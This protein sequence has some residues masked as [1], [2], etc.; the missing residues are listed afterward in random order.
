MFASMR[1]RWRRDLLVA[2]L[3]SVVTSAVLLPVGWTALQQQRERTEDACQLALQAARLAQQ[4]AAQARDQAQRAMVDQASDLAGSFGGPRK[5]DA[6]AMQVTTA[7]VA[8]EVP[9]GAYLL[10]DKKAFSFAIGDIVVFRVGEKNY[11]GRV[12]AVHRE[13]GQ[14]TIGRNKEADRQVPLRQVLGSGGVNPR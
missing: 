8:P 2:L 9:D 4:D 10:I 5:S 12:L 6:E 14:L 13:A 3:A 7:A 1:S 11:L